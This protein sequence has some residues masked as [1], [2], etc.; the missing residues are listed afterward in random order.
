MDLI[1]TLERALME[2][3]AT[4]DLNIPTVFLCV[5][6]TTIIGIYIAIVYR[7]VNKN[8]IS[9]RNFGLSLITLSIITSSIILTIQSNIVVS[10]GMVGALS[11]V[12]FRTAIK[13]PM[14]LIFF[15]WSI[16]AGIICGAGFAMIAIIASL[17]MTLVIV[18]IALFHVERDALVLIVNTNGY[19]EDAIEA[20]LKQNC[21]FWKVRSRSITGESVNMA[22]EVRTSKPVDL[23]RNAMQTPNVVSASLLEHDG[24]IS[25]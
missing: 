3:Y 23:L 20:V 22:I 14:D 8:A 12:R 7:F 25:A 17:A 10:L 15:F 13:N 5:G 19:I 2:G 1:A 18:I 11:I 6:L 21:S 16:S 4:R 24:E 9:D